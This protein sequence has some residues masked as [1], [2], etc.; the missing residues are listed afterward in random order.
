MVRKTI[1]ISSIVVLLVLTTSLAILGCDKKNTLIIS[2]NGLHSRDEMMPR[3]FNMISA[4]NE[5]AVFILEVSL[6]KGEEDIKPDLELLAQ[7]TDLIGNQ[8]EIVNT[9]KPTFMVL[10]YDADGKPLTEIQYMGKVTVL[11]FEAL[12]TGAY[13][14]AV[15]K[16]LMYQSE[17]WLSFG[18]AGYLSG[19]TPAVSMDSMSD[20]ERLYLSG[21]SFCGELCGEAEVKTSKALAT[22]FVAYLARTY[23]IPEINA[24]L[25]GE[26]SLDIS[27]EIETWSGVHNDYYAEHSDLLNGKYPYEDK[28]D[29][30]L[31]SKELSIHIDF[32]DNA[33]N[34][35][36]TSPGAVYTYL[37]N[38]IFG[39]L[40][41]ILEKRSQLVQDDSQIDGV[42][43]DIYIDENT[44]NGSVTDSAT[45]TV[46]LRGSGIVFNPEHEL[47]H[48]AMVNGNKAWLCEG[49]TQ[50][51]QETL[52][53]RKTYSLDGQVDGQYESIREM[54]FG[55][56]D[57][58]DRPESLRLFFEEVL[59]YY[60]AYDSLEEPDGKLN[61]LLYC[62]ASAYACLR[63]YQQ[64]DVIQWVIE[65][66]SIGINTYYVYVSYINYLMESGK[67][68]LPELLK[69]DKE[70]TLPKELESYL[71]AWMEE[72]E[73][74]ALAIGQ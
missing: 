57:W 70:Q 22:S 7:E 42:K 50:F 3:Q 54:Y 40:D 39:A 49:L 66:D 2:P 35:Y 74:K 41:I 31:V 6:K 67:C 62:D 21:F 52:F 14:E 18:L 69:L 58:T 72:I 55:E 10:D 46:Y 53:Y 28:K 73:N 11:P 43:A 59:K 33:E 29:I 23:G 4:E 19:E 61:T 9:E 36:F 15:V 48:L 8:F 37:D 56:F 12:T 64:S 20:P 26:S 68:T 60:T 13:K 32:S 44:E 27:Q 71:P 45:N 47:I 1:R 25:K 63:Q 30:L 65:G 17:P 38:R 16:G 5:H 34:R 24:L 51:L